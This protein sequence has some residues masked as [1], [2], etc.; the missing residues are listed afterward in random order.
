MH[1]N[2]K[3]KLGT[4]LLVALASLSFTAC[5]GDKVAKCKADCQKDEDKA[6]QG[7][8]APEPGKVLNAC[9]PTCK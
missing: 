1:A 7:A 3:L 4:A 5:G 6:Q 9:L 2:P 8:N